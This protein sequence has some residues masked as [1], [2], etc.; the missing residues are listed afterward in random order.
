MTGTKRV[1]FLC[2]A[3]SARSQ[4]AQALV[5]RFLAPRW[6]ARSAGTQPAASVHPL[7]IAAM[8]ELGIDISNQRPRS[9]EEFRNERFDVIVTLCDDAA[10]NCPLWI[11]PGEVVHMAFPDP[12]EARGEPDHQLDV[13]RRVRDDIRERV[14]P[15]LRQM[16]NSAS[17]ENSYDSRDL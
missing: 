10:K 9:T 8:A 16:N 2:T 12:A 5:N 14:L 6:E 17:K 15:H 11:G 1:L 3:N 7:A 13:F 4:M